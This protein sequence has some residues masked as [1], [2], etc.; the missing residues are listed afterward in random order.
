M[1]QNNILNIG[2]EIPD[3]S[4]L[5]LIEISKLITFNTNFEY[6]GKKY[7]CESIKILNQTKLVIHTFTNL[8]VCYLTD[9]QKIK[10]LNP[11]KPTI[12]Y[13]IKNVIKPHK[14]GLNN[15]NKNNM[16]VTKTKREKYTYEQLLAI[17]NKPGNQSWDELAKKINRINGTTIYLKYL[18]IKKISDSEK[19]S[20]LDVIKSTKEYREYLKNIIDEK[21]GE[22]LV[23]GNI[24][25]AEKSGTQSPTESGKKTTISRDTAT[26]ER[27]TKNAEEW[28]PKLHTNTIQ[29]KQKIEESNTKIESENICTDNAEFKRLQQES[30]TE[31]AEIKNVSDTPIGDDLMKIVPI[32]LIDKVDIELTPQTHTG[33]N[34][35]VFNISNPNSIEK[36]HNEIVNI[37][38]NNIENLS[39]LIKKLKSERERL[40]TVLDSVDILLEFY[41]KNN[42]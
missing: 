32:E 10:I 13:N 20:L 21:F 24:S 2:D 3:L 23:E 34:D 33:N 28:M 5:T 26:K 30:K 22:S 35:T 12:S 27:I 17:I 14:K 9:A 4:K 15:I 8:V 25:N 19:K 36:L 40:I 1:K 42:E 31:V 6:N 37:D 29:S 39:E 11:D 7:K 38:T 41:T 16:V 18:Q